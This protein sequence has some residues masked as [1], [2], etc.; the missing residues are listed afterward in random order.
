[1]TSLVNVPH[2]VINAFSIFSSAVVQEIT[3]YN[4]TV[5]AATGS[6][7]YTGVSRIL[8]D[9]GLLF[10]Y[11][12]ETVNELWTTIRDEDLI[13]EW[14]LFSTIR[15]RTITFQQSGQYDEWI[16]RLADGYSSNLNKHFA[17]ESALDDEMADLTPDDTELL[18]ILKANP[19]F[20]F[21]L[22]LGLHADEVFRMGIELSLK[23]E[24][25]VFTTDGKKEG[26]SE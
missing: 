15:W 10:F 26:G 7:I 12:K 4:S 11:D 24:N 25:K 17:A 9:S 20:A 18:N 3:V 21:I 13:P 16:R 14:L 6:E 19:W 5:K 8:L 1:M 2:P 22:T 23:R